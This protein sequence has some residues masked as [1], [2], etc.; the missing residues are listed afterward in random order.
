MPES[1]NPK[2][3]PARE[4][5]TAADPPGAAPG[6]ANPDL[7][8]PATPGPAPTPT[9]LDHSERAR[10]HVGPSEAATADIKERQKGAADN[11]DRGRP[12]VDAPDY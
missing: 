5:L 3:I 8:R 12:A 6:D 2:K 7:E 4:N 10:E 11:D 1:R 9:D